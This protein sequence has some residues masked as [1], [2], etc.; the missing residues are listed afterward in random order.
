[1]PGFLSPGKSVPLLLIPEYSGINKGL[2]VPD[3]SKTAQ[4]KPLLKCFQTDEELGEK[5][6]FGKK[7]WEKSMILTCYV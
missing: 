6:P 3:S 4:G 2:R 1:M 7:E 5:I